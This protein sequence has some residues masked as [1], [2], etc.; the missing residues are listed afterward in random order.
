MFCIIVAMT[1][2]ASW[3]GIDRP[4]LLKVKRG[5]NEVITTIMLNSI[6]L[7]LID[8]LFQEFFRCQGRRSARREDQDAAA[9]GV[10]AR[11]GKNQLNSFILI[12][13]LV[14]VA[15]WLVV[16]K[17]RFGFRLRASG[18]NAVA[19]RTAGISSNKM[20]VSSMFMSGAVAGLAGMPSLLGNTHAY[21]PT[22]PDGYGFKGIAVA[23]LG[24]NRPTGIVVSALLWGFLDSV[25][26]PLQIAKIPQSIVLVIK[27]I[28]LLTVVIVNEVVGRRWPNEPP[29]APRPH[30]P[31]RRRWRMSTI[32]ML[33]THHGHAITLHGRDIFF[34]LQPGPPRLLIAGALLLLC[35]SPGSSPT[36]ATS[37]RRTRSGTTLRVTIPILLAGLAGLWA[38]RAGIVNIGIEG[39]M[40][41]GTWF[42]GWGAWKCGPWVGLAARHRRRLDR[43]PA[44]CLAVVQVQR[45]PRDLRRRHQPVGVRGDALPQRAGVHRH[46]GWRHQPVATAEVGHSRVNLPF[47]A[48]GEIFGWKSPRHLG[49]LETRWFAI[50][51]IA[52]I[53]RGFV[54]QRVVGLDRRARAGAVAPPGCCGAPGSACACGHRARLRPPPRAWA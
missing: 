28:I 1:A 20:I 16:F 48:G 52:G 34:G 26:G 3:P 54:V 21:G 53:L 23:L 19:A 11:P 18:L 25:A 43:R 39:M 41:F 15:F 29:T 17:S 24:R 44:A 38:E 7:S 42:G 50:G 22:R 36:A 4:Q 8:W 13:L 51:D 9:D 45:Q 32:E 30:S 33:P 35:R 49:W 46:A 5:V 47:L 27:A 12:A 14:V 40:I 37:R 10:H 6:A 2:G 31:S